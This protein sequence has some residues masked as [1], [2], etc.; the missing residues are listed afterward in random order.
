MFFY[1]LF[2]VL[3]ATLWCMSFVLPKFDE[4]MDKS[5]EMSQ[6]MEQKLDLI[7]KNVKWHI[8]TFECVLRGCGKKNINAFGVCWE[9]YPFFVEISTDAQRSNIL[10]QSIN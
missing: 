7:M 1:T 3:E 2:R 5:Y 10:M 9:L 4:D 8:L 6:K